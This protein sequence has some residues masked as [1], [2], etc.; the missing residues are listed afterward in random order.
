MNNFPELKS[1]SHFAWKCRDIEETIDFYKGILGLSHVHTVDRDFIA[2]TGEYFPHKQI[3]FDLK[4]GSQLVFLDLG[5]DL[6]TKTDT[7]DWVV[8]IAIAVED[9]EALLQAKDWLEI[10]GIGVIGPIEH[11]SMNSIY[12]FDSNGLRIEL[13]AKNEA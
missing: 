5:D 10:N 11:E 2:S 7:D 8:R 9:E 1:L 13:T 6:G 4:D 3:I 12:F